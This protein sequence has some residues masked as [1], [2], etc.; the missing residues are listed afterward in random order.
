MIDVARAPRLTV[1]DLGHRYGK[2]VALEA[3]ALSVPAGAMV[4]LLGPNGSGKS[5]A[6]AMLAGVLPI[7]HGTAS[8]R[9]RDG[10]DHPAGSV[11]YR[12]RLGVVFQR[13]SLDVKLSAA[14]NLMLAARMHGLA[15]RVARG[16]V[17]ELLAWAGLSERA[18]DP[19]GTFSG[20]MARRLEITRALVHEP[21]LVLL[22]EPT[23]GLDAASFE[24]TWALL[25]ELR[26]THGVAVVL[27]TH[28][29][30]EGALCDEL[31]VLDEGRVV[32]VDSPAT[33]TKEL[34]D[35]LV[36]LDG[37]DADALAAEVRAGFG[38]DARVDPQTGAVHVECA[39]GHEVIV[40]LVEGLPKGRLHAVSLR[41]PSLADAFLKLTG[42]SL[43]D[44]PTPVG[45][46]AA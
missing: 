32:R 11:G 21:E 46:E 5:T 35:D 34:A 18:K 20:G 29:P 17:A 45:R 15:G 39:R 3:L 13:P 26:R 38:L 6:L 25:G 33:L 28:R 41:R 31:V 12:A 24:R 30:E 2:R 37:S 10:A 43:A 4:G 44:D 27:A 14:Q 16:R 19:V 1:A 42:R 7:Q 40:R 36:V 8:W 9:G 23:T 22:D